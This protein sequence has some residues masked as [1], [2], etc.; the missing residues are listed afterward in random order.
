M[1]LAKVA[2]RKSSYREE[3]DDALTMGVSTVSPLFFTLIG[4]LRLNPK[5]DRLDI[6]QYK[7]IRWGAGGSAFDW[8]VLKR[9]STATMGTGELRVRDV[10]QPDLLANPTLYLGY[11]LDQ[12]FGIG[13]GDMA[14]NRHAGPQKIRDILKDRM[15][16]AEQAIHASLAKWPWAAS[17]ANQPGGLG[18]FTAAATGTYAGVAMNAT[19]T[20]DGAAHYYWMPTGADIGS[21]TWVANLLT[22]QKAAKMQMTFSETAGGTGLRR[23]P[24]FGVWSQTAFLR[25]VTFAETKYSLHAKDGVTP[26]NMNMVENGWDNMIIDNVVHFWDE[27]YGYANSGTAPG[28]YLSYNTTVGECMFGYSTEMELITTNARDDGLVGSYA[29]DDNDMAWLAG[30]MGVFKTGI[31]TVR[32]TNPRYFQVFGH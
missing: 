22:A 13:E 21:L 29:T 23:Q 30:K 25:A 16:D 6:G 12:T 27:N 3:I 10:A 9:R 4:G 20:Y 19:E 26:A 1:P 28:K 2:G 8:R 11:M 5:A 18:M 31:M 32:F 24:D 14:K 15:L 7:Q 17:E